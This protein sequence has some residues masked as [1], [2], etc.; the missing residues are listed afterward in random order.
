MKKVISLICAIVM[1]FI[2]SISAIADDYEARVKAYNEFME[3]AIEKGLTE[4]EIK[5]LFSKGFTYEKILSMSI[6]QIRDILP[7][8]GMRSLAFTMPDNYVE[9][10]I[11]NDEYEPT[12]TQYFHP[13]TGLSSGDFYDNNNGEQW[14]SAVENFIKYVYNVS[15]VSGFTYHYYYW[16]EWGGTSLGTH[17]GHD[18]YSPSGS[19]IKTFHSG[20]ITRAGGDGYGTVAIYGPSTG[21]TYCYA[22][23]NVSSTLTVG[24]SISKGT[25]IGTEGSVG[26]GG[27]RHLHF[28]VSQGRRDGLRGNGNLNTVSPY[29]FM[30]TYEP[31]MIAPEITME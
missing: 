22:H 30:T 8:S 2:C 26:A 27:S 29:N 5:S 23:L 1:I 13:N 3:K 6:Y 28:E 31:W 10:I 15:S 19:N 12:A 16:G 18:M 9:V 11:E 17:Q 21:Y 14:D 20:T 25:F 4:D 24:D 7:L